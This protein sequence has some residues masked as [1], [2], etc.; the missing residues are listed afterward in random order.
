MARKKK[1]VMRTNS[2]FVRAIADYPRL[3]A[4]KPRYYFT[5]RVVTKGIFVYKYKFRMK[6]SVFY[7]QQSILILPGL[8]TSE[9]WI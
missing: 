7:I 3:D 5:R 9:S 6:F 1:R 4:G 8:I 2:A